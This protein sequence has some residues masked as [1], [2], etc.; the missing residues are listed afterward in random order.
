MRGTGTGQGLRSCIQTYDGDWVWGHF[1]ARSELMFTSDCGLHYYGV[2]EKRV[3]EKGWNKIV[4][5]SSD[6][7]E[8]LK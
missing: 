1:H 4:Y 8:N 6:V 3:S 2:H 5:V 7:W